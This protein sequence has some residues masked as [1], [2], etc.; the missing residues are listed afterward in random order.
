MKSTFCQPC[1]LAY[2]F[3]LLPWTLRAVLGVQMFLAVS[4]TNR[5]RQAEL[6]FRFCVR[7]FLS[8]KG[9]RMVIPQL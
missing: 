9:I 8:G 3:H 4:H 1:V 2:R 7:D 5:V 6:S